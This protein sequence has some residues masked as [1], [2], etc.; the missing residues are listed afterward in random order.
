MAMA[1]SVYGSDKSGRKMIAR[2]FND[3]ELKD[4]I[5]EDLEDPNTNLRWGIVSF[6]SVKK[7][8][9][10]I[11]GT[12]SFDDMIIDLDMFAMSGVLDAVYKFVP[13]GNLVPKK[14]LRGYMANF[15]FQT[16][17]GAEEPYQK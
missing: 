1:D 3:T 16:W 5:I 9:M 14:V 6:P 15:N 13:L 11:R 4:F 10:A 7:R 17:R 2:N 8:I 12:Q